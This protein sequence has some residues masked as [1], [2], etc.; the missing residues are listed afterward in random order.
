MPGAVLG[1][2]GRGRDEW[3]NW[4]RV[5]TSGRLVYSIQTENVRHF[6]Q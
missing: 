2:E 1:N 6:E 5:G 3:D 4:T